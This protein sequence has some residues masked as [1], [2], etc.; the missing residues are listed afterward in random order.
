MAV[1]GKVSNGATS[2]YSFEKTTGIVIFLTQ[3]LECRLRPFILKSI[4][5]NHF[6]H[7]VEEFFPRII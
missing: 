1:R 2:K 4:N 7:K 6:I 5:E 3:F